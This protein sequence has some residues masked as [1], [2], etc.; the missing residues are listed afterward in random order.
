MFLTPESIFT[1]IQI[2]SPPARVWEIF[3]D[4][5]S[6]SRWNP[7]IKGIRGQAV[8]GGKIIELVYNADYFYLP[9]PMK[10]LTYEENAELSWGGDVPEFMRYISYGHHI[11]RFAEINGK[12]NFSHEAH[13]HGVMMVYFRDHIQTSVRRIHN[14][15]NRALKLRAEA[16]VLCDKS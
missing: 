16:L 12:T 1:E 8:P 7:F 5:E 4:F 10:I 14:E 2:D 6:Y 3:T 15:M 11:F 13:L 9:L